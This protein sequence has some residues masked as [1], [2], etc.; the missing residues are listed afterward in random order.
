MSTNYEKFIAANT[1]LITCMKAIPVE[2]YK[3][4]ST[5]EQNNVCAA[6]VKAVRQHIEA[7]HA[8]FASI[9]QER[10]AALEK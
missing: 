10:I 3:A 5:Q 4:M 1:S 9:L 7:G 8:N 6:E 2:E